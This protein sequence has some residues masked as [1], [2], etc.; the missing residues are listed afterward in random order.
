[1]SDQAHIGILRFPDNVRK[2]RGMYLSTP[3][4]C[5][6]E[7][8]DNSVDEFVAG[9]CKNIAIHFSNNTFTV[10]DDGGGIP[11][12][13][14]KDPEFKGLSE[15]QVAMSTL[16]AGGKFGEEKGYSTNT[17]GLNGV[18][19]SC[20]NAVSSNFN[21]TIWNG[22]KEFLTKFE[23]G[24]ATLNT[25]IVGDANGKTGTSITFTLDE[26]IWGK[27]EL[28]YDLNLID[29]RLKQLAFLNP[30]LTLFFIVEDTNEHI[31]KNKKYCYPNGIQA[32][33]DDLSYA[34]DVLIKTVNINNNNNNDKINI[35][36]TYTDT[37]SC[38]MKSFVNNIATDDGGV[39]ELG[40]KEGIYKA[41][42][43]YAIE[44]NF[45]KDKQIIPE[46]TREGL[47]S[48]INLSIKDP[49]FDGQN[50]RKLISQNIRATI[51]EIVSDFFYDYLSKNNK[52]A[53]IL[54]DKF[55]LAAKVRLATKK[56]KDAARGLKAITNDSSGIPGK[57]A[58]CSS[59]NPEECELFL[60]EGDSAG[61]SAKQGRD[62]KTQAIL[63]VFGK[64]LNTE[65]VTPDK[66][67]SNIKFQ[68]II[69]ALKTGIGDSFDISKL[70]YHKVILFSDAD[71][72]GGHIQCLHMTFF[73]RYMR[74]LIENGFL[75][76]ACPPLFKVFKKTGKKEE[77]HYLYTKEEL[78]SFNTEGYI[79]QRYKGLVH[80]ITSPYHLFL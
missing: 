52:T 13:E 47:I 53:K 69:K 29:K 17:G 6:F 65:K 37:Y 15:A 59:K 54:M 78:D 4:H 48:I 56:A 55:L 74:P 14:C 40:F 75:Y 64:V 72:D 32:Y 5:L 27:K 38:I 23:K 11:I 16:H 10:E 51:R 61:G 18:G 46:D 42:V 24:I 43:K 31:V 2:R 20:V 7:I 21:L 9:R 50:K 34:K 22:E 44:N 25:S 36:F 71:V 57:L 76:A 3:E 35:S 19:A 60:V 79:V 62:R 63:P 26:E 68:D 66:V 77:V 73:Y 28:L 30:G 70:R 33:V 80:L 1:M 58:D 8:V 41:I 39:H 12:T 49:V 45:I 67:Y